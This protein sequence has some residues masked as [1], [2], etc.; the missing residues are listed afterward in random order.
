MA[1]QRMTNNVKYFISEQASLYKSKK[2]FAFVK[3]KI[4]HKLKQSKCMA[5]H[6]KNSL[7]I[8]FSFKIPIS[9]E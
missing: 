5:V 4:L 8:F 9:C 7:L 1:K 2:F 3:I 6:K